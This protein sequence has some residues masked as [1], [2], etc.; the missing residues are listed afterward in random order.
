MMHNAFFFFFE[1]L[2]QKINAFT[3]RNLFGIVDWLFGK[4][5]RQN[6]YCFLYDT[7]TRCYRRSALILDEKNKCMSNGSS[8]YGSDL[9]ASVTLQVL[10]FQFLRFT[11]A[12]WAIFQKL[13][14]PDL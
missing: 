9:S 4:S 12:V 5:S 11:H 10:Q 8:N 6:L 13:Y 3:G 7:S 2:A 14:E 1:Q